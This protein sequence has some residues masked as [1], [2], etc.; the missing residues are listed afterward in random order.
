[1]RNDIIKDGYKFLIDIIFV[2]ILWLFVS[3]LG[4][5]ITFGAATTAMFSVSFKL[6]NQKNQTYI[7]REFFKSFKENF[8]ESTIVWFLILFIAIPLYFIYNYATNTNNIVLILS[9][10]FTGFQLLIFSLYVF[11]IIAKFKTNSIFQLIKN[12]FYL[13]NSHFF[14][15][16]KVLGSLALAILLI[17]KVHSF[18]ILIAVGIY[19]ILVSFHLNKIFIF[20]IEKIETNEENKL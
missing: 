10:Y 12:T 3:A 18:F 13:G 6:L 20:Y 4:I 1:M 14:T 9:V 7:L 2:N 19:S 11:P 15:T 8:I 17:V 16:I 5:F